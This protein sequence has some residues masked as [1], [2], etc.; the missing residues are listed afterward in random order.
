MIGG[1][2]SFR[3]PDAFDSARA[4]GLNENADVYAWSD[5][6][7]KI[8]LIWKTGYGKG[9]FV[10]DNFG[11]CEKA[12]R[13]FFAAS[14][15]LL[16]DVCVYPVLNGSAFYLD[17]FPSPVPQGDGT[18]VHRDYGATIRE[19]YTNIW[20]PDMMNLAQKY[21]VRYTGAIIENYEDDTTGNVVRAED[22]EQFQYFG[23]MLLRRD[24]EIAYHGYNHQPLC[25]SDIDYKDVL[26]YQT[27]QSRRAMELAV[28]ELIAFGDAMFPQIDTIASNYFSGDMAYEQEFEVAKDGL[29]EQPRIISGCQLNDYMRLAAVSELNIHFVNTHFMHPDDLLDEDRGAK[30]GWEELKQRLADYMEWL[31][32]SA[33]CIRNL[34]GSEL[35]GAIRRFAALSVEKEVTEERVSLKLNHFYDEA[36]LM[37]RM[38]EGGAGKSYGRKTGTHHRKYVPAVCRKNEIVIER[39]GE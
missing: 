8:P 29:V 9:T 7:K 18:Y 39:T 36:Y 23:N 2:Q 31:Y 30:L 12:T 16:E 26:P 20:W 3:I 32:S 5:D 11:I 25:L 38:N 28:S 13:G 17:D 19:F 10:V 35:S 15:S 14:Y 24:G 34:T 33:P 1:G 37:L 22:T 6:E 27:W 4:V 21:G